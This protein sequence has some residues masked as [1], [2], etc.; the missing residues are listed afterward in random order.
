MAT[1]TVTHPPAVST[2]R[3][4]LRA[5]VAAALRSRETLPPYDDVLRLIGILKGHLAPLVDQA[6][7]Q[8]NEYRP[9][10]GPQRQAIAGA[11]FQLR[12]GPGDGLLSAAHRLQALARCVLHFDRELGRDVVGGGR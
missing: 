12:A 7:D 1:S 8:L 5:A 10:Y 9:G 3:D 6:K 4:Q 11:E 2:G